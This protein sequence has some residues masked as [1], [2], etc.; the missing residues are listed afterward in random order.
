MSPFQAGDDPAVDSDANPDNGLMSDVVNLESG[1]FDETID[2]GFFV[3]MDPAINIEK[4][5]R[6]D[7]NPIALTK[8][9]AVQPT[10]GNGS[11]GQD[12][13]ETA[14][15]P[16]A[17]SFTYIDDGD[18]VIDTNQKPGQVE[19]QNTNPQLDDDGE[20]FV[21]TNKGFS[22]TVEIGEEFTVA[23]TGGDLEFEIFDFQ[24]VPP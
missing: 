22:G 13:C 20:I 9:V 10:G 24:G 8:L 2:A 11:E 7:E 14:G 12:A 16:E 17:L 21:E 19:F 4:F 23:A 15:K 6:V 3:P 1:E 5:V 18:L